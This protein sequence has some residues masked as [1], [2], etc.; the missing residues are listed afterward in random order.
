MLAGKL[1]DLQVARVSGGFPIHVTGAL[2]DFVGTDAIEVVAPSLLRRFEFSGYGGEEVFKAWLW[3]DG[4]VDKDVP[5][6][7]DLSAALG[8]AEREPAGEVEG[9]L[10]IEAALGEEEV[11][12]FTKGCTAGDDGQVEGCRHAAFRSPGEVNGERRYPMFLVL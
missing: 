4:W 6:E 11:N 10:A 7:S 8:E 5:D 1:A 3:V 12:G 2:Q 9:V